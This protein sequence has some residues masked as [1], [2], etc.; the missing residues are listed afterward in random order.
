MK[1]QHKLT[2]A[3]AEYIYSFR[4]EHDIEVGD[5][6]T[7]YSLAEDFVREWRKE[8]GQGGWDFVRIYFSWKFLGDNVNGNSVH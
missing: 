2:E 5:D 8:F 7:D 1:Y 4:Q 6:K 3:I